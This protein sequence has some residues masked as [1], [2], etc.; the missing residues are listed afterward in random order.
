MDRR[1]KIDIILLLLGLLGVLLAVGA[2]VRLIQ[3]KSGAVSSGPVAGARVGGPFTLIDHVGAARDESMIAGRYAMIYFGFTY[4]PAICPTELQKM[5]RA[6]DDAGP[7]GESIVPVFVSIDPERDT[8]EVMARYVAQFH[9]RLIGL[10]GTQ[11]QVDVAAEAYKVFARKAEDPSLSEYTMD[12]TSYI[13]FIGP[14][15]TLLG[16]Y[17]LTSTPAEIAAD[18]QRFVKS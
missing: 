16:I 11:E 1:R 7:A 2:Q 14:D 3:L 17:G 5:A 13:Y 10:T 6:M 9:P 15:G 4:C 8:P 12:H 18:I